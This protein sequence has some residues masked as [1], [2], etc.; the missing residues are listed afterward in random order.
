[1]IKINKLNSLINPLSERK[2]I[3]KDRTVKTWQIIRLM[4]KDQRV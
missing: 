2:E 4:D 1:M 3:R